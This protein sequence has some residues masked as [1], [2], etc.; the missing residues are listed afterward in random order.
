MISPQTS[1]GPCGQPWCRPQKP[2]NKSSEQGR[3]SSLPA[4]V[5]LQPGS[6]QGDVSQSKLSVLGVCPKYEPGRTDRRWKGER[7]GKKE[8]PQALLLHPSHESSEFPAGRSR[9]R[10]F[11]L[12]GTI[13]CS[14]LLSSGQRRRCP[15]APTSPGKRGDRPNASDTPRQAGCPGD[16]GVPSS[17]S[18]GFMDQEAP[19]RFLILFGMSYPCP[20]A[21]GGMELRKQLRLLQPPY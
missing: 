9:G 10:G 11:F 14:H 12:G 4:T 2:S 21:L 13:P 16:R 5:L 18:C 7:E 6:T 8:N 3:H 17:G 1:S 15:F 20:R 19:V